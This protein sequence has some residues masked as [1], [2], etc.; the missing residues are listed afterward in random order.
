[1]GEKFRS[2]VEFLAD[3]PNWSLTSIQVTDRVKPVTFKM[4]K[5]AILCLSK[6]KGFS[7]KKLVRR[8]RHHAWGDDLLRALADRFRNKKRWMNFFRAVISTPADWWGEYFSVDLAQEILDQPNIMELLIKE[9]PKA[10]REDDH[11]L[12]ECFQPDTYWARLVRRYI[13]TYDYRRAYDEVKKANKGIRFGESDKEKKN[14]FDEKEY[15]RRFPAS[16][17]AIAQLIRELFIEM[18]A[19]GLLTALP[20]GNY[21]LADKWARRP[22][23]ETKF[24]TRKPRAYEQTSVVAGFEFAKMFLITPRGGT[25]ENP[26]PDV[27]SPEGGMILTMARYFADKKVASRRQRHAK[28]L[29]E[30]QQCHQQS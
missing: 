13:A 26:T 20:E 25:W 9:H 16:R 6:R 10:I 3:D 23:Y 14:P 7:C 29:A 17:E 21:P 4:A 18:V 2:F 27:F 8:C 5:A 12:F 24:T 22:A 15:S 19:H 1:M 28:A 11:P 30:Y